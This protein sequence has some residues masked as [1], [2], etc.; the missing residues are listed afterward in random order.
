[1]KKVQIEKRKHTNNK[2]SIVSVA[3]II[4]KLKSKEENYFFLTVF[5]II[6]FL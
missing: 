6:H 3:S 4:K 5:I 1:M 2:L